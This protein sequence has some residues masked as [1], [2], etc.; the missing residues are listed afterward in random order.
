MFG[1]W[2]QAR[3][4]NIQMADDEIASEDQKFKC[5]HDPLERT[6]KL[7]DATTPEKQNKT[8]AEITTTTYGSNNIGG[9]VD[10]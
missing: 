6:E 5:V 4:D 10:G 3:T 1:F 7:E 8:T 9:R 2:G